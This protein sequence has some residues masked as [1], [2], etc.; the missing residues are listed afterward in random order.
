MS[1]QLVC[2]SCEFTDDP[3]TFDKSGMDDRCPACGSTDVEQVDV[4]RTYEVPVTASGYVTVTAENVAAAR[5]K[6][7]TRAHGD[8]EIGEIWATVST[9]NGEIHAVDTGESDD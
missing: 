4:T 7:V 2:Q 9:L 6:A 3:D 5:D 1:K 8:V